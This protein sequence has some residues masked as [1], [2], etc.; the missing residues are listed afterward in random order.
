MSEP[1][2]FVRSLEWN[3]ERRFPE[4]GVAVTVQRLTRTD[5]GL[6]IVRELLEAEL[7]PKPKRL[8]RKPKTE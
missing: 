7:R 6:V 8:T 2:Q 5:C 1:R 4:F 3:R